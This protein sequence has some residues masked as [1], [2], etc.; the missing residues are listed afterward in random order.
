MK[1]EMHLSLDSNDSVT[2]FIADTSLVQSKN[3]LFMIV[4]TLSI[5]SCELRPG[6]KATKHRKTRYL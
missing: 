3:A 5:C 6:R 1:E 2:S 4:V